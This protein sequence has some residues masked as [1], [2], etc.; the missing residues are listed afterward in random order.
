MSPSQSWSFSRAMKLSK[1]GKNE[2]LWLAEKLVTETPRS[3]GT[4]HMK[5]CWGCIFFVLETKDVGEFWMGNLSRVPSVPTIPQPCAL[6]ASKIQ[7]S[8]RP[9]KCTGRSSIFSLSFFLKNEIQ[10][11]PP[12]LDWLR[13]KTGSEPEKVP[14]EMD[15]RQGMEGEEWVHRIEKAFRKSI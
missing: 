8:L 3:R 7:R 13:P 2:L 11:P 12:S 6:A 4:K 10:P 14:A 15:C 1:K 9:L 5:L